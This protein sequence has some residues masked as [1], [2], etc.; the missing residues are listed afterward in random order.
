MDP[1]E[2]VISQIKM[3][4]CGEMNGDNGENMVKV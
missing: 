2:Q 3:C 1:E 4:M